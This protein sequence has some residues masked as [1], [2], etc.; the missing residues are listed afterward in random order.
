M[1]KTPI[2]AFDKFTSKLE[3]R[4]SSNFELKGFADI[5]EYISTGNYLLNAQLSGSLFGGYPNTRS[6]GMAG[7]SGAG[8]TFLCLN[9]VRELQK[10]GYLVFYVDTEGAIDSADY[11]KFGCDLNMLRYYRI[12]LISEIK[13]FIDGI[14][15]TIKELR[16]DNPDLKIALFVDSLGQLDTDKSRAD[17][18]KGKNAADMG[19]R[20]KE[21]R[22]LFKAFTLELS[23]LYV[24]FIFTNHTY[25]GTDQYTGK[26]PQGGGGPEFAASII[27]MLSKG[28]LK[29]GADKTTV[30]G[31]IVRSKTRKNRLAKP[32][33][34]EF[35]ISHQKGMNPY[36][37][38]QEYV[39][40]ENCGI[41]RGKLLTAKEFSKLKEPDQNKCSEFKVNDEIKY[42]MSGPLAKNYVNKFTGELIPVKHFFSDRVFT[43]DVL[44]ELD[45]KIIKPTFK[46][47]DTLAGLEELES[48]DFEA[49]GDLEDDEL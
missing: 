49:V 30:T 14:I 8:K 34:I 40:W 32:I 42:F 2:S 25:E 7:D 27:L 26:T 45:E 38:L 22:A 24:P 46:Y 31:I 23:N 11:P 41:G 39:S 3:K 35:H 28:K 15:E 5:S 43:K 17:I 6:I 4:V 47:P 21:L 36:V 44:L 16:G 18:K 20:A 33:D 12:G 9:A 37:G 19:L 1:A 10:S 29:D 48:E 13:F